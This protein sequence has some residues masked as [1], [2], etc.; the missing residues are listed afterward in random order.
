MSDATP[1]AEIPPEGLRARQQRVAREAI[2]AAVVALLIEG[3][4]DPSYVEIAERSRVARRT[5]YRYFPTRGDLYDAVGAYVVQKLDLPIEIGSSDQIVASFKDASDISMRNVPLARALVKS[6]AGRAARRGSW[7]RRRDAIAA[8][9]ADATE[10]I[11]ES[12]RRRMTAVIQ[13]LFGSHTW[14]RLHDEFDL[15]LPDAQ[16][17]VAWALDTLIADIRRRSE[18]GGTHPAGGG[19]SM[20][21]APSSTGGNSTT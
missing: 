19:G 6:S 1:K 20:P 8:A 10:G 13:Y 18:P 9:L 2:L 15:A 11:A 21:Q 12:E 5:L 3:V 14:V 4:E 17:A 16:E 7:K